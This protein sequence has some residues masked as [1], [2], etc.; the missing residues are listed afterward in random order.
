ME[1]SGIRARALNQARRR[2]INLFGDKYP[3]NNESKDI[4]LQ[5][6]GLEIR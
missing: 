4:F 5:A 1:A 3:D 6:D 2:A